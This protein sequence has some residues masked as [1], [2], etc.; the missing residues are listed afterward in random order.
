MDQVLH[1]NNKLFLTALLLATN[2]LGN[3]IDSKK[4]SIS[5]VIS[6]TRTNISKQ[7]EELVL[8][9]LKTKLPNLYKELKEALDL[10]QSEISSSDDAIYF[11]FSSNV[12]VNSTREFVLAASL[13]NYYFHTKVY[14][15]LQGFPTKE[16]RDYY[17]GLTTSLN[18][19]DSRELFIKNATVIFDPFIFKKLNITSAPAIIYAKHNGDAYPSKSDIQYV[20]RG[21][22]LLVKFFE[23]VQEKDKNFKKH[24]ELLKNY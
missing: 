10:A 15:V 2:L 12:P 23:M 9:Q 1:K 8:A 21:D 5:K 19:Y 13:I 7:Q 14:L 18:E 16:F 3:N 11:L 17:L 22:I 6:N 20:A 24:F 4:E